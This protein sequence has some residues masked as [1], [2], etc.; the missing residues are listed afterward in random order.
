[1]A[2]SAQA[3]SDT[4]L[5]AERFQQA[6]NRTADRLSRACDKA[7]HQLGETC[8]V[9]SRNLLEAF[10]SEEERFTDSANKALNEVHRKNAAAL[11]SIHYTSHTQ[12]CK[13][14]ELARSLRQDLQSHCL[15]GLSGSREKMTE[16][17]DDIS[18]SLSAT[19]SALADL[20]SRMHERTA[21][22]A[23]KS[24][25]LPPVTNAG[26]K[27]AAPDLD[28]EAFAQTVIDAQEQLVETS[29]ADAAAAIEAATVKRSDLCAQLLEALA[30]Q[31][32]VL[33]G[34]FP[35]AKSTGVA[36]VEVNDL[37]LVKQ[38]RIA[39]MKGMGQLLRDL[40]EST[41][42]DILQE[43]RMES[44]QLAFNYE[45]KMLSLSNQLSQSRIEA[46]EDYL[47][48]MNQ[49]A[50]RAEEFLSGE[51]HTIQQA[52]HELSEKSDTEALR[53]I[54]QLYSAAKS[55]IARLTAATSRAASEEFNRKIYEHLSAM[56]QQKRE[57][58][59][60]LESV[61]KE[62]SELLEHK[63]RQLDS[64]LQSIR[65]E[66]EALE[67]ETRNWIAAVSCFRESIGVAAGEVPPNE[68]V[69]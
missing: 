2:S 26:G 10:S 66:I 30:K 15:E 19:E 7:M 1:M 57:M 36:N 11:H 64:E 18:S 21:R 5:N 12:I 38:N 44:E 40:H 54:T 27:N 47:F 34:E 59:E 46:E 24:S 23:F 37:D 55:E 68:R 8:S 49:L 45:A 69:K 63:I 52:H 62:Y 67:E 29:I 65:S 17:L 25:S 61:A 4:T 56:E 39:D 35:A 41:M 53:S 43:S 50:Q 20:R 16:S 3:E 22:F 42:A 60:Q 33:K 32:E 28:I 51:R 48:K 13:L 9:A 14:V 6:L 31:G 58:C